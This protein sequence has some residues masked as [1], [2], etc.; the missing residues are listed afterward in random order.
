MLTDACSFRFIRPFSS[1][2]LEEIHRNGKG[3]VI[4]GATFC[5]T[6]EHEDYIS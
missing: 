6:S 2:L 4:H 1:Q 5:A 3:F